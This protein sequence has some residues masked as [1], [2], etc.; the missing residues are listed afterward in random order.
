MLKHNVCVDVASPEAVNWLDPPG[1]M[2]V[3]LAE[4]EITGDGFTL[5]P[6][7]TEFLQPVAILV[8]V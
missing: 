4:T 2:V 5:T 6:I 1:Q 8:T 7:V 3:G